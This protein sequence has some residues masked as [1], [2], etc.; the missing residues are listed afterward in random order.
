VGYQYIGHFPKYTCG[1]TFVALCYT[2]IWGFVG[3]P[4][5][6][7]EIGE[8]FKQTNTLRKKHEK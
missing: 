8:P 5:S 4:K 3:F 1:T 7:V 6:F 2:T